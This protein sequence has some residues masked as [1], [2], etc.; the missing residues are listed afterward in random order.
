MRLEQ[1]RKAAGSKILSP[2][3]LD[4]FHAESS[5]VLFAITL[6]SEV[7]ESI[8]VYM[9]TIWVF[10]LISMQMILIHVIK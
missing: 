5:V 8:T 3:Q 9:R 1:K 10:F 6:K 2:D 7:C 4:P